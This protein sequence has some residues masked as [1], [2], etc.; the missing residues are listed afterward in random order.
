[1][2]LTLFS[3][4]IPLLIVPDFIPMELLYT[5][6]AIICPSLYGK[7]ILFYGSLSRFEGSCL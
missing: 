2:A 6:I 5:Y 1:M 4:G 3:S 7:S